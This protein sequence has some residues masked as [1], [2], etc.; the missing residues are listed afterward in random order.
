MKKTFTLIGII[1]AVILVLLI[2]WR[3]QQEIFKEENKQ[4]RKAAPVTVQLTAVQ[5]GSIADI[6]NFTGSLEADS[7]FTVSPKASGR[8]T[9]LNYK[10]GDKIKY[11]DIVARLDDREQLLAVQEE[12]AALLVSQAN[13][14]SAKAEVDKAVVEINSQEANVE[15]AK[16]QIESAEVAVENAE[17]Q[18]ASAEVSLKS[19]TVKIKNAENNVVTAKNNIA[20]EK[21]NLAGAEA[22]LTLAKQ[23]LERE[24]KGIRDET[25]SQA[26]F[27]AAKAAY[28]VKYAD[29]LVAKS[30]LAT[31]ENNLTIAETDVEMAQNDRDIAKSKVD[32]AN[33]DLK[34]AKTKVTIAKTDLVN[35]QAKV[36]NAKTAKVIADKQVVIAEEQVKKQEAV[37]AAAE[38][39]HSYTIIKA[40]WREGEGAA[41]RF[42]SERHIEPGALLAVNAPIISIVDNAKMKVAVTA[43]EKDFARL[44]VG[45]KAKVFVQVSQDGNPKSKDNLFEGVIIRKSPVI[46]DISRQGRFEIEIDNPKDILHPGAFAR[47]E[48]QFAK[49]DNVLLVPTD[50]ICMRDDK[51]GVFISTTAEDN[52]LKASFIPVTTGIKF[53]NTY[54]ISPVNPEDEKR[55]ETG[56]VVTIGNHLLK[57]GTDI[58]LPEKLF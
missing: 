32:I 55:L 58:R 7:T 40:E 23:N 9:Q 44:T 14:D 52:Q 27:D 13:V 54:E 10:L 6:G 25:S 28:D 57:E 15:S 42:V 3:L 37:L 20:S 8:I 17:V 35:A 4:E 21:A 11:G 49:H 34:I 22:Q 47:L 38:E 45:Q 56:K 19:T 2:L 1:F 5:R 50:A 12:K 29:V 41:V 36:E 26:D 30:K 16:A 39:R 18:V 46:D 43:V 24:E 33:S 53:G 51:A 31:A 48:I